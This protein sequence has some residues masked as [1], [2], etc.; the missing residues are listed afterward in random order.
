MR[1][2]DFDAR[3][4]RERAQQLVGHQVKAARPG[5]E[6]DLLLNPHHRGE[7]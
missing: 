6:R 4:I 2:A 7:S 3:K 1:D 5:G